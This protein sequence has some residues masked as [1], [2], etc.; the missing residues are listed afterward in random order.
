M[1]VP[2]S[3]THIFVKA[4]AEVFKNSSTPA[5]M[6]LSPCNR[7]SVDA[8]SSTLLGIVTIPLVLSGCYISLLTIYMGGL[9]VLLKSLFT[10]E[11]GWQQQEKY[12]DILNILITIDSPAKV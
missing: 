8:A 12:L 9:G 2:L 3:T 10:S 5:S 6:L 4:F 1:K 7:S 11:D